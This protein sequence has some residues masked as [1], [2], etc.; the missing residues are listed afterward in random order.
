MQKKGSYNPRER[1]DNDASIRE[2]MDALAS[3]RFCPNEH[4]LFRW[5]FDELVHRGD[6]YFHIADFPSYIADPA[7]H[8]RR[9][10]QGRNLVAQGHPERRAHR[11]V[12][13][14]PHSH[15]VRARHLAHWPVR[16]IQA[17]RL[18]MAV[19]AQGRLNRCEAVSWRRLRGFRTE[20]QVAD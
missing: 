16:K 11:Q 1:Y 8:Q 13:Q 15:R 6:R 4:G 18:K 20:Q 14:R 2:V 17:V 5:I 19:R 9:I 12:F 7:S 10:S 3:D